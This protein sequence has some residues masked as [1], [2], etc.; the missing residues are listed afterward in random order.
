MNVKTLSDARVFLRKMNKYWEKNFCQ[1]VWDVSKCGDGDCEDCPLFVMNTEYDLDDDRYGA[2][3]RSYLE[4]QMWKLEKL[5]VE[6]K[7]EPLEES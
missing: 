7:I 6:I 5:A 3:V 1:D 2:C 4:E